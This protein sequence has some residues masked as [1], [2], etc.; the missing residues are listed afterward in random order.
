[1]PNE[2]ENK[3]EQTKQNI[4]NWIPLDISL[5]TL[6]VRGNILTLAMANNLLAIRMRFE[7]RRF[8][9]INVTYKV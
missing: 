5:I 2:E 1:M 7:D 4:W 8:Y 6:N 3:S 9:L